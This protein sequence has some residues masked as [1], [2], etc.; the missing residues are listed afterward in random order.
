MNDNQKV[1]VAIYARSASRSAA[2]CNAQ[3]ELLTA[4]IENDG[5][6]LVGTYVDRGWQGPALDRADFWKFLTDARQGFFSKLYVKDMG[7]ISRNSDDLKELREELEGLGVE[8]IALD[9]TQDKVAEKI[10]TSH[11]K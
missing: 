2:N 6:Q 1:K 5:G 9:T 4:R 10:D 11:E 3:I 7:R 8:I